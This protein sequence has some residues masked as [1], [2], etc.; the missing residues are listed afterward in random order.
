MAVKVAEE[1]SVYQ[2]ISLNWSKY[3]NNG[4]TPVEY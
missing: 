3:R 2:S 1:H 4:V